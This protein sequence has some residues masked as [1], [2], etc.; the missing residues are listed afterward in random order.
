MTNIVTR[1]GLAFGALV[2]LASTAIAGAPA[3]AAGEINFA[4]SAGT[5]YTTIA[6]EAFV[7]EAA[8]APGFIP[9]DPSQLKYAV[10]TDGSAVKAATAT[11][12]AGALTAV[13]SA[14]NLTLTS[15]T[16]VVTQTRA[17]NTVRSFV[18]VTPSVATDNE[19]ITVTAFV[20]SNNDGAVTAGEWNA[21]RT[22][23]F[24]K[25]ADVTATL[26]LTQPS[27]GDTTATGTLAL[28]DINLDQV[29]SAVTIAFDNGAS[30]PA[31]LA[32]TGAGAAGT[33]AAAGLAASVSGGKYTAT[34]G[35]LTAFTS[36]TVVR[37]TAKVGATAVGTAVSKTATAR[38]ISSI[39]AAVVAGDNATSAGAVRPNA[40]F[41]VGATVLDTASTPAAAAGVALKA[42]FATSAT[43]SATAGSEKQ[44]KIN[45]TTYSVNGDLTAASLT[46]TTGAD[47]KATVDVQTVGFT[48]ETVTVT[49]AAQNRT[50]SATATSTAATYT[51]SDDASAVVRST[52]KNTAATF[53]YTV[54]D[55]YGVLSART[56]ER[57]V[58]TSTAAAGTS[59]AVQFI[60]VSAGKATFSV[61][62]TTDNTATITVAAA[63][64]TSSYD[65][66][67]GQTTWAANGANV[68]DRTLNVKTA[69][70]EFSTPP[71][72]DANNGINN[73]AAATSGVANSQKIT[74][75][76][77]A[78]LNSTT[79][80]V[81]VAAGD[82]YAKLT[83][84]GSVAGEKIT[85]SGTDVYVAFD[86]GTAS[87]NTATKIV[88]ATANT[89]YV[90][91]NTVGTK[92]ISFTNGTVTKTVDVK[93]ASTTGNTVRATAAK[94]AVAVA[95]AAQSGRAIDATV[96]VTDKWGNPVAGFNGT[97]SVSGVAVV[98]GGYTAAVVTDANGQATVKLSAGV[99][100]LG[101]AVVTFSDSDDQTSTNVTSVAKTVT[102]GSTDG[103]ID[104]LNGKRASVTWSF[105]KGKR[106]AVYLDG[107]RRYNIVQPGDSELN[108][109]F[110]LKK[111]SHSIKL[112][113]GGVIVDTLSVKVAG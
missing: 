10:T 86:G 92:T 106:V 55:Q 21:A 18:A 68:A 52:D 20:D 16:G 44:V 99:N 11:T 113:I 101:D 35:A 104:V 58:V 61:T 47:G 96:T 56:N 41:K 91:A 45:G 43:L 6:S 69:A 12:A 48:T 22:L 15:N 88:Q 28:A 93:F 102:F 79:T 53:N 27:E 100:D 46:V 107:V 81:P 31:A 78:G 66:T 1:K 4:A 62:P 40:A 2:A 84:T 36:S 77:L 8:M 32:P 72:V 54:K 80:V 105:A 112:V 74:Q 67:T 73:G 39:T 30:T 89:V 98:N 17:N 34:T 33:L 85:V 50:S 59:P 19:S 75:L 37:L 29:Q 63:L 24:K 103:Y 64:Q 5:S 111:G 13:G 95:G 76:D 82:V 109:Q 110:N 7:L 14:S 94:F 71:A 38:T 9:A 3:H 87:A 70:F 83:F 57:L 26:D 51:V 65:S 108:L 97:A 23:T 90:A 42:T 49:F 25:L 60:A